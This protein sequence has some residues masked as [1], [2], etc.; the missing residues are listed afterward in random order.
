MFIPLWNKCLL[1]NGGKK[2][3]DRIDV[4]S[5]S[6]II[7]LSI[8]CH[9]SEY[10]NFKSFHEGTLKDTLKKYFPRM[11]SY[12]RFFNTREKSHVGVVGVCPISKGKGNWNLLHRQRAA[13]GMQKPK[14][15]PTQN[16]QKPGPKG[17]EFHGLVLWV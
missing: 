6:E 9:M 8:L 16:I 7:A 14:N 5:D 1:A 10:K 2:Y 11:P 15:I 17:R 12:R 4:L 3:K 13:A